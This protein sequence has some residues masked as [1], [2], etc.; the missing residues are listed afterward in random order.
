MTGCSPHVSSGTRCLG[1]RCLVVKFIGHHLDSPCIFWWDRSGISLLILPY[2]FLSCY[3]SGCCCNLGIAGV[4]HKNCL[5]KIFWIGS[6]HFS[7]SCHFRSTACSFLN[8]RCLQDQYRAVIRSVCSDFCWG[9]QPDEEHPD[10]ASVICMLAYCSYHC[11]LK[12]VSCH[13]QPEDSAFFLPKLFCSWWVAV[14]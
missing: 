5:P 1:F 6:C 13:W 14:T 7:R 2:F 4:L 3:T 11:I 9:P 10:H 8:Q 12:L